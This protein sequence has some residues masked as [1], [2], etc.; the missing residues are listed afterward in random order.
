MGLVSSMYRLIPS[1]AAVSNA[2]ARLRLDRILQ[3]LVSAHGEEEVRRRVREAAV[4]K[5]QDSVK[6]WI[7]L[8][9]WR[10]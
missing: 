5:E 7:M 2:E 4:P 10:S 1:E 6:A 9:L 3:R 8:H